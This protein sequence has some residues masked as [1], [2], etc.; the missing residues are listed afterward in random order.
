MS[1]C[2]V[3]VPMNWMQPSRAEGLERVDVLED[4]RLGGFLGVRYMS[5]VVPYLPLISLPSMLCISGVSAASAAE[6][7]ELLMEVLTSTSALRRMLA[8]ASS[9]RACVS[10]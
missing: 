5:C 3:D 8:T 1:A 7:V 2:E 9:L 10:R 6:D 4:P